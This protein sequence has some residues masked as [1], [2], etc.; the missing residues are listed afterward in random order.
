MFRLL[1][2]DSQNNNNN[3]NKMSA[4]LG[5]HFAQK[6]S[7]ENGP[8]LRSVRLCCRAGLDLRAD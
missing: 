1:A 4:E 5:F 6:E 8:S 7:L 3:N 2:I